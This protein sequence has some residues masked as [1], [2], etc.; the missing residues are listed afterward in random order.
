MVRLSI[1]LNNE[2]LDQLASFHTTT[3]IMN[4]NIGDCFHTIPTGRS[5]DSGN[6][7]HANKNLPPTSQGDP[8]DDLQDVDHGLP[9]AY[10]PPIKITRPKLLPEEPRLPAMY[11]MKELGKREAQP[12]SSKAKKILALTKPFTDKIKTLNDRLTSANSEV[13]RANDAGKKI[14]A[15]GAK[16]I[17]TGWKL[18]REQRTNIIEWQDKYVVEKRSNNYYPDKIKEDAKTINN[19]LKTHQTADNQTAIDSH[20]QKVPIG[21]GFGCSIII[22]KKRR[23]GRQVVCGASQEIW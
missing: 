16:E 23:K 14:Y 1:V 13:K 22:E 7:P 4:G 17:K 3:D 6:Q 2:R 12:L 15:A 20:L 21:Q 9:M 18:L 19:L 5:E 8:Q 11:E 10:G